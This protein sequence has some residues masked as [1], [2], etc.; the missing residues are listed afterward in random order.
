MNLPP[1]L[2][3]QRA[4]KAMGARGEGWVALQAVLLIVYA[5]VPKRGSGKKSS[6]LAIVG[7][8]LALAG[9]ELLA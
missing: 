9:G 2:G 8:G 4:N 1:L 5:A 7:S 3:R 6:S